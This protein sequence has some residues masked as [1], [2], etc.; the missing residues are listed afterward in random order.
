MRVI[1]DTNVFISAGLKY[2]SPPSNAVHL[3]VKRD[4]L[5]KSAATEQELFIT[6]ARPRLAVL[7][8]SLFQDWLRDVL[9]SAE[10]VPI[11]ERI[12]ACRD[13]KD[14]KF[15]EVAVCGRADLIVSG[16]ADLL[17][18]NPFRDIPIV[19]PAVFLE[20]RRRQSR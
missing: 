8:P 18:I 13:P 4:V 12:A 1:I 6:L 5:L 11:S 2:G 19:T 7:I 3:A 10:L 20:G 17:A 16:D 14:D 15:L 9:D